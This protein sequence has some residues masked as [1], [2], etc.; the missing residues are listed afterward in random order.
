MK[1]EMT[2][3]FTEIK[4]D[5]KSKIKK[6]RKEIYK[7]F[8]IK[9]YKKIGLIYGEMLSYSYE[10]ETSNFHK[11]Y[12]ELKQLEQSYENLGYRPL[13]NEQWI[14]FAKD[15]EMMEIYLRRRK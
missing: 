9:R 13:T 4:E 15:K 2:L 10:G 3:I 8:L 5:I 11:F 1:K 7:Y 12:K 6:L 14:R